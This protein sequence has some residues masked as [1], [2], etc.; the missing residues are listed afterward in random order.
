V[1]AVLERIARHQGWI[2]RSGGTSSEIVAE[3]I[4]RVT[5]YL[6]SR[7]PVDD[8][9]VSHAQWF[10]IVSSTDREAIIDQQLAVYRTVMDDRRSDEDLMRAYL[11]GTID[12]MVARIRDLKDAGVEHLI[13]NPV[14]DDLAQ[15][16]LFAK[17]IMPNV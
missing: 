3:D 2:C 8:F 14:T 5:Q 6:E 7:R 12:E 11:F 16:D 13:V 17:E 1:P 4:S 10:H 9:T 15:I